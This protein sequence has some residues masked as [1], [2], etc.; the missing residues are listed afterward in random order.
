MDTKKHKYLF[1][2]AVSFFSFLFFFD[3][4]A[5]ATEIHVWQMQEIT[6]EAANT[7]DN[8]YAD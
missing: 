1:S 4:F 2:F 7:Y 5:I 8:Y 3:N 6:L